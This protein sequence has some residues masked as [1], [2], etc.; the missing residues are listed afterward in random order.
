MHARIATIAEKVHDRVFRTPDAASRLVTR[1]LTPI[2]NL[3]GR[4]YMAALV[5][6]LRNDDAAWRR[7]EADHARMAAD[8]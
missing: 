4:V 5:R 8:A 6:S 3:I 7:V 1:A 2:D